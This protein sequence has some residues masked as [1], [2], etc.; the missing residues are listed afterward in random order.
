[1]TQGL[2]KLP[3]SNSEPTQISRTE[4][5]IEIDTL[6]ESLADASIWRN[7]HQ[8]ESHENSLYDFDKTDEVFQHQQYKSS[9][10]NS[11]SR[12]Y[13]ESVTNA[14]K[15]KQ[16]LKLTK[17]E[18]PN[19]SGFIN[20]RFSVRGDWARYFVKIHNSFLYCFKESEKES[21]VVIIPCFRATLKYIEGKD[22]DYIEM[23]HANDTER[24]QIIINPIVSSQN[25]SADPFKNLRMWYIQLKIAT[26]KTEELNLPFSNYYPIGKLQLIVLESQEIRGLQA[27]SV[28]YIRI[29]HIPYTLQT[30]NCQ[31]SDSMK[32]KQ[33]FLIPLCDPFLPLNMEL[34]CVYN[35]GWLKGTRKEEV[36]CQ[37]EI[38]VPDVVSIRSNHTIGV[39][40]NFQY[41]EHKKKQLSKNLNICES[42]IPQPCVKVKIKNLSDIKSLFAPSYGDYVEGVIM[43]PETYVKQHFKLSVRRVRR[44]IRCIG[45]FI[46]DVQTIF[47]FKFPLFSYCC[48]LI[49]S[50]VI[51]FA[52]FENWFANLILLLVLLCIYNH[53]G[54]N[55]RIK[56]LFVKCFF[57]DSDL[58]PNYLKPRIKIK[59]DV[60]TQKD[61]NTEKWKYKIVDEDNLVTQLIIIKNVLAWIAIALTKFAGFCEK[62]KNLIMWVE[63]LRTSVF[64]C[65]GLIAYC[66]LA[67]LPFRWTFLS[68]VWANFGVGVNYYKNLQ[69]RNKEVATSAINF[70]VKRHF[71]VYYQQIWKNT[72]SIWPTSLN[73][74]NFSKKMVEY[75][76]YRL[77]IVLPSDALYE[78]KTPKELIGAL[79]TCPKALK[80][81]TNPE[82]KAN[83]A[84]VRWKKP[85][86]TFWNFINFIM[87][88]PS[89]YYRVI[90]PMMLHEKH[91]ILE[92]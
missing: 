76:N 3:Q 32:W 16:L 15:T 59:E 62:L 40:L 84:L 21:P 56:P 38:L 79:S 26:N 52:E 41:T 24:I 70:L 69:M 11:R 2:D 81:K 22:R 71:P 53:Q 44:I 6:I 43:Y 92:E 47:R 29:T 75:L 42:E 28:C 73:L 7:F 63:P 67:V 31:S 86:F 48:F 27:N 30:S 18:I 87:N 14:S 8:D 58:N 61:L 23:F 66:V 74:P 54:V 88:T 72:S 9:Q 45:L 33:T 89:D 5:K 17:Q 13:H 57:K 19:F 36:V 51:A 55:S 83:L 68:I 49:F 64:I 39:K 35:E 10:D 37:G 80:F 78:F 50:Y 4:A 85:G 90:H 82:E 20:I 34:V 12:F 1:L 91:I 25:D 46:K 65:L 77:G 60:Q